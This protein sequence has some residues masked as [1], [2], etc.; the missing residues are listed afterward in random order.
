MRRTATVCC[1]VLRITLSAAL[2]TWVAAAPLVWI[3][4]DGL[5]AGMVETTGAQ[6]AYKFLVGW[7]VPALILA[8][9]LYGLSVAQRR[10][11][12]PD[13]PSL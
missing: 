8:A 7:G 4:R 6:A 13:A 9:P 10:L 5:A 3:L 1:Q 11:A 2:A 12:P